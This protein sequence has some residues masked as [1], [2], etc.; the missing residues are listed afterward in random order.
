LGGAYLPPLQ[1]DRQSALH[2]RSDTGPKRHGQRSHRWRSPSGLRE[3]LR[4]AKQNGA[5]SLP[6]GAVSRRYP[7]EPTIFWVCASNASGQTA[8][9]ATIY[10]L[11]ID[12]TAPRQHPR[13]RPGKHALD[14]LAIQ[15]SEP[16]MASTSKIFASRAMN[17]H[18][19]GRGN[20]NLR[21]QHPWTLGNLAGVTAAPGN[22]ALTVIATARTSPIFRNAMPRASRR[23]RHHPGIIT[24]TSGNEYSASFENAADASKTISSSTIRLP[25]PNYSAVTAGLATL[26]FAGMGGDDTMIVDFSNGNPLPAGGL[27]FDG[28]S[29]AAGD[30]LDIVGTSNDDNVTL[31]ARP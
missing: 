26:D 14:S 6:E 2:G 11:T 5:W 31:T 19:A 30:K 12:A 20:L 1:R 13:D 4:G 8:F 7:V 15:F 22:Y 9:D 3:L 27:I 25:R 29:H 24:G 18:A 16:S 17:Q 28:G 21:R 10:E 23:L